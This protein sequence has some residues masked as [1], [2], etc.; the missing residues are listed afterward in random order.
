MGL[1]LEE[2][3]IM[4]RLLSNRLNAD[5]DQNVYNLLKK[6]SKWIDDETI[7]AIQY[8]DKEGRRSF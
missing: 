5:Y 2:L 3:K 1:S 6:V 8:G 4:E 7:C